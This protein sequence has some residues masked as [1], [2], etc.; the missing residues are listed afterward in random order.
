LVG[1]ILQQSSDKLSSIPAFHK[2]QSYR[3][4]TDIQFFS[5]HSGS[6]KPITPHRKL[7]LS[8]FS[9]SRLSRLAVKIY[10]VPSFRNPFKTFRNVCTWH[11]LFS[12]H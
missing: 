11:S 6:K 10:F 1:K 8:V 7:T 4:S 9:S 2:N 3:C 12:T 5:N